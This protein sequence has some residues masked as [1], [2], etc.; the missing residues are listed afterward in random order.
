MLALLT[1]AVTPI[2]AAETVV[3]SQG[4][5]SDDGGYTVDLGTTA[6][7]EWGTP[8]G[9]VGPAAAHSG[10]GCWGT[11]LAGAINRPAEG[12]IMS[13]AIAL[14][15]ITADQLIRVRFWAFVSISGMYDRGQF[16]VSKD[17][18]NW[19]SL[20]QLYQNMDTTAEVPPAWQK[21]EFTLDPSY[22]GGSIYLRFR[23]AVPYESASF[24]CG[25]S[26]DLSGVYIDDIAVSVLDASGTR[27]TFG[28]KPL[29]DPSERASCPWIA[30]WNGSEFQADNDIYSVARGLQ[31]EYTDYYRLVKPLV[32]R[33]GVYPFEVQELETEDSFTDL[34][35][36]LQ[37]D[38]AADVAVAPND[39]GALV[40]YAP[41]KLLPPVSALTTTGEDVS[42]L[43]SSQDDNGYPAYSGDA[44]VVDFG[45]VDVSQGAALV[46]R[47]KGFVL[48]EG[49]QKPFT[50]PPAII[51]QTRDA[52]GNWQQRGRLR[53]RY[54]YS[55]GAFDLS[56]NLTN[57]QSAVV[58]L[59]SVSHSIKY[60]AI[61][62]VG[63]H[64][65]AQP[66]FNVT[67]VTP[68][69]ASF[70]T[71][72]ILDKL[73]AADADRVKMSSG[74][75]FS[76][77]FP[78]APRA[79]Q[80]ERD[81]VLVA[82]GYYVPKSGS[83][84]IYTWNGAAWVLRDAFSYPGSDYTREFDLSLFLPD[85]AGE[86]KVRVWQ[87]YQYEPAGIDYVSLT[88][89]ASSLPLASAW[90]Y[91][92]DTS[93]LDQV[94]ASDDYRVGWNGCPRDRVTQFAFTAAET[95][96][97][98]GVCPVEVS[99]ASPPEISWSYSDPEQ[100]QQTASE[101]QIWTGPG[102][103]GTI[104]WNP[105]VFD[106][107]NASVLYSGPALAPGVYYVQVR[108]NDGNAWGPWCETS[109]EI[110]GCPYDCGDPSEVHGVITA[111]DAGFILRT[112]VALEDCALCVC[113]VDG[114]GEIL[115]SDA[116]ADLKY[117][118]GLPQSLD[119]PVDNPTTSTTTTTQGQ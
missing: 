43:V 114:S 119:C 118:V 112:S 92:S 21:Y 3:Y 11:N 110:T 2:H 93:I 30:P 36:L 61:D 62:F 67:E 100:Q 63:L 101:V 6:G 69:A 82:K 1:A 68:S 75:K 64:A 40:G 25:G 94:A 38:H 74:E 37:I 9:S 95:N 58:R 99:S 77:E 76:V 86:Y 16:F 54:D 89:G 33:D 45:K 111:V 109:F 32:A 81:F 26:T 7:W 98:P 59:V 20:I 8:G 12:S 31:N 72:D 65:G 52:N 106:D 51:V 88:V 79:P 27:K 87:D 29:E 4:F 117:A 44:V 107:S 17:A 28:L 46:V 57:G 85:P 90:D 53:P 66:A 39:T 47:V 96:L 50:G 115:S 83:Y 91:R 34:L 22:A 105:P 10:T 48:G 49:E 35:A 116:L 70:G 84:L 102:A 19:E 73:T 13:P 108:A 55:V 56:A 15:S 41:S 80:T 18:T 103:T 42:D 71:T 14:P 23:A 78:V 113:D 5:E 97:P 24:N 104:V 60:H